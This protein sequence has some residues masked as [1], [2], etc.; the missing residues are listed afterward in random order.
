MKITIDSNVFAQA[1]TWATKDYDDKNDKAYVILNVNKNGEAYLAH[2]SVKNYLKAPFSLATVDLSDE[3]EKTV[4][5]P[6]GGSFLKAFAKTLQAG[7]V[8]TLQ[9][10][11]V[12]DLNHLT[13]KTGSGKVRIPVLTLLDERTYKE[14]KFIELGTT[15]NGEWFDALT[16]IGDLTDEAAGLQAQFNAVHTHIDEDEVILA[17]TDRFVVGEERVKFTRSENFPED[18]DEQI[19]IPRDVA[20]L[21][22]SGKNSD[23]ELTLIYDDKNKAFGYK[24]DD[25]RLGIFQLLNVKAI[26]RKRFDAF[27]AITESGS[28]IKISKSDLQNK[29]SYVNQLVRDEEEINLVIQHDGVTVSDNDNQTTYLIPLTLVDGTEIDGKA[30]YKLRFSRK[31]MEKSLKPISTKEIQLGWDDD[32]TKLSIIP[33]LDDG[34]LDDNT[35]VLSQA[36]IFSK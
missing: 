27:K 6:L 19:L 36:L 22:T 18:F 25:G 29:I 16:K 3:S 35:W 5:L 7:D 15:N 2:R 1:I 13:C 30:S 20:K 24:F 33:V 14:P 32:A 9:R 26:E 21:I 31:K 10:D 11:P 17:G 12:K 23:Q 34:K 4:E 28:F 8:V